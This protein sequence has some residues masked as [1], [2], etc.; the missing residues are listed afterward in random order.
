MFEN[1]LLSVIAYTPLGQPVSIDLTRVK[2][3]QVKAQWYDPRVGAWTA[4]GQ[5]PRTGVQTFV[6][7][8]HGERR[9]GPGPRYH[10]VRQARKGKGC[11]L[12][13]Y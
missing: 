9:L 3:A 7:P 5:Y 4:V 1:H 6:P 12:G 10:T 11:E 8:Y 2:G 13:G